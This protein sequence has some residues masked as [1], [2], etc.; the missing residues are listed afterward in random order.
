MGSLVVIGKWFILSLAGLAAA[1]WL[2]WFMVR[3]RRL[4]VSLPV[5]ALATL[6]TLATAADL[7]NAHYSY[8]P[9]VDDVVGAPSWPTIG[10]REATAPFTPPARPRPYGSVTTLTVPGSR[11][12]F[13]AHT[14]MIYL[15]APYFTD[16]GRRFPVVYL[17]HGTP[18]AP[19]DWY[20][21]NRAAQIGAHLTASGQPAIFVAPQ[22]SHGWLDDSECV[23]RP[24]E[25]I[26]TYVVD[27]VIPLIDRQLRTIP[28]RAD[29]IFAGVSAGGFCALN[30]GLRHRDKVATIV[31][32]SGFDR[33]T[34]SGGMAGL[35]G[36]QP[37]LT[38][39][40][41]ANTPADY[42]TRLP[43]E[44]PMRVWLDCGKDDRSTL[45]DQQQIATLLT[46]DGYTVLLRLR[47]GGHTYEVW[48]PALR[49]S[50]AWAIPTAAVGPASG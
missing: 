3:R 31:D 23:D 46:N 25:H 34:H 19:I 49:D 39:L 35:F 41:A 1:G 44:P 45:A 13:G 9:R 16:P 4:L 8:L 40:A 7:V 18:G 30:L 33:P 26:E 37:N 12:G 21:A 50:L 22:V 20:R 42:A 10:F 17:L 43:A 38:A 47:G 14:A 15:P 29:R 11:S 28:D 24:S 5:A 27:D 32:L 2:G 36:H 6:L 48:R